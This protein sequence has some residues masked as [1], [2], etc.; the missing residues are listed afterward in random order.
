MG[1]STVPPEI[2]SPS[3][4]ACAR[5]GRQPGIE[6]QQGVLQ[7]A[8]G[9][10]GRGV[11]YEPGRLVQDDDVLVG[12]HDIECNVL[13]PHSF[14]VLRFRVDDQR[15]AAADPERGFLRPPVDQ[16]ITAAYPFLQPGARMGAEQFRRGLIESLA[17]LFLPG[18]CL[19]P[20]SIFV[21]HQPETAPE[22]N[23]AVIFP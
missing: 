11:H 2:M 19:R 14:G 3:A 20:D 8:V 15:L 13:G 5:Q 4:R 23:P 1:A 6:M 9:V 7:R 17:R 12:E 21:R 10:A 16:E 22:S 18:D